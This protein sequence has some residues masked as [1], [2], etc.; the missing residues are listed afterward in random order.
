M[1]LTEA[2][3]PT[4][5]FGTTMPNSV[6]GTPTMEPVIPMRPTFLNLDEPYPNQAFTIVVWGSNRPKF[7]DPE[8][9]YSNRRVCVSGV[10]ESY[11][12]IPQIV[13]REPS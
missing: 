7:G 10:I 11:R 12:S 13:A 4:A 3:I 2:H 5:V 8:A 9:K 6:R 1:E